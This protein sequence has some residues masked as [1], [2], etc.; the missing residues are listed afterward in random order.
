MAAFMAQTIL[1]PWPTVSPGV[2]AT[3]VSIFATRTSNGTGMSK[4]ADVDGLL[5]GAFDDP[6][7]EMMNLLG[8]WQ[9]TPP[10]LVGDYP[11]KPRGPTLPPDPEVTPEPQ[12]KDFEPPV[13][14]SKLIRAL[15]NMFTQTYARAVGAARTAF[16]NAHDNWAEDEKIRAASAEAYR[17]YDAEID[18]YNMKRA[19]IDGNLRAATDTY[20][21]AR[22]SYEVKLAQ[23]RDQLE[24]WIDKACA[25]EAHAIEEL[26]KGCWCVSPL[27]SGFPREVEAVYDAEQA[28]LLIE[29]A[30]PNFENV[31]LVE[32]LKTGFHKPVSD[33][34]RS[35]CQELV[36]YALPLR[37]LHELY[38]CP[39][40]N[41]VALIGVNVRMNYTERATGHRKSGIVA[42][43]AAGRAAIS[44]LNIRDVDAKACFR[45]LKGLC[46][47]SLDAIVPVPPV[48]T[49]DRTDHRIVASEVVLDDLE[50]H[51]NLAAMDWEKFEHLVRE[52]FEKMFSARSPDAEVRVTRAS[53][54]WGV[55]A[56]VFDP[57]PIHGGKFVIQAKRYTNV[58]DVAAVR[59][60][61]GTVL[62]EGA[63]RGFLVTTSSFGPE[64]REFAASK[65]ITL[66]DGRNLL[67]LF[68][69]HG[70][71]FSIDLK[72][73]KAAAGL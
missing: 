19:E 25:G 21:E 64:S 71:R 29:I 34:A 45:K 62:N 11:P 38:S 70:Y 56:I 50:Q 53:R 6:I 68:E 5:A 3:Y 37:T 33:R 67:S 65:Q 17:H 59:D 8:S 27:P 14:G 16:V 18:A 32:F 69:K 10:R 9:G 26:A 4:P 46:V 60:L 66:I 1:P 41:A 43:I 48:L 63:N 15:D 2:A 49:L 52:L 24:D 44:G 55:D 12:W 28:I 61:Y 7:H 40:L 30:A 42:T 72:A 57:D 31:P 35:R 47:P 51:T 73:A 39:H 36:L 20:E 23:E 22:R 54:D 58:V 13:S